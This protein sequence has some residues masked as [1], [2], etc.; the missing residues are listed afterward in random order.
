MNLLSVSTTDSLHHI[1][2]VTMEADMS[3]GAEAASTAA[4]A[5]DHTVAAATVSM[6]AG[7]QAAGEQQGIAVTIG[8]DEVEVVGWWRYLTVEKRRPS[9]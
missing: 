5:A 3:S 8:A 6:M 1:A 2:A 7:T 4:V 9:C